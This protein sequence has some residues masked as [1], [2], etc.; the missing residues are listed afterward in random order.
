VNHE[1]LGH[2]VAHLHARVQRGVRVLKNYLHL[3]P[4]LSQI[5]RPE[6]QH[7]F[8]FKPDFA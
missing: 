3:A 6:R 7:V 1:R 2:D 4:Q 8:R 5:F